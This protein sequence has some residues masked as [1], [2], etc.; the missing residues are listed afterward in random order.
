MF[1]ISVAGV[2]AMCPSL[3]SSDATDIMLCCSS[4]RS[5]DLYA[6]P[7]PCS[8]YVQIVPLELGTVTPPS[9][10]CSLMNQVAVK[11]I[12]AGI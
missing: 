1:V 12:P 11:T 5:G 7:C 2:L 10:S 8:F 4:I 9:F 3:G 6:G